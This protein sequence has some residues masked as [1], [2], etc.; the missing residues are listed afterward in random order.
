MQQAQAHRLPLTALNP[1]TAVLQDPHLRARGFFTEVTHPVAGTLPHTREPFR[2]AATPAE[3]VR[4]AP[5]LGQHTEEVLGQ[6]LGLTS[7]ALAT[8]RQEGVIA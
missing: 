6:R 5:L 8:L 7:T 1:P 2:M 4:P 3:P